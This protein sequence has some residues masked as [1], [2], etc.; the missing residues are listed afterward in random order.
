[1]GFTRAPL[2]QALL[3]WSFCS[4]ISATQAVAGGKPP[5]RDALQLATSII[6]EMYCDNQLRLA[7]QLKY[8]NVGSQ[9]LILDRYSSAVFRSLVSLNAEEARAQR[10]EQDV[11]LTTNVININPLAEQLPNE[12]F[13]ILE[14][15]DSYTTRTQVI[16]FTDRADTDSPRLAAGEYVLQIKVQT[17]YD[18][19]KL[20]KRL[21]N[22]WKPTGFL[23]TADVTS[24]PMPFRVKP[25]AVAVKCP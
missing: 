5:K 8:T 9:R 13:V 19:E 4:V 25:D 20:A 18:S 12:N 17:W 23:W 1:M 2:L 15:G 11:Q 6:D 21:R 16:I 22:L 10:Y 24:T 3:I 7:L 14:P